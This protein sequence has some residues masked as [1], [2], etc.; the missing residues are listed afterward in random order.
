M[1]RTTLHCIHFIIVKSKRYEMYKITINILH[2]NKTDI[3][4]SGKLCNVKLLWYDGKLN[5]SFIIS[6][7]LSEQILIS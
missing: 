6:A 3:Q 1:K 4:L 2:V 7:S 5:T